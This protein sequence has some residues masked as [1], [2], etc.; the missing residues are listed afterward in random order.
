MLEHV[1]DPGSVIEACSRLVKPGG[2]VYFSTINRNP[3]AYVLAIVGAEY[4]LRLLAKGTHDYDKFIKP[5]EMAQWIRD[6][7]LT[8]DDITGMTYN[9]LTK[10]YR[11]NRNNVDVNYLVHARKPQ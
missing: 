5:S 4:I 7:E 1:P 10:H 9:P 2:H 6:A 8:L 11:L 3:K